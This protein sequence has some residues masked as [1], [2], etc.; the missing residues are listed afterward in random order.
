MDTFSHVQRLLQH[1]PISHT[2]GNPPFANYERKPS[3]AFWWR[4]RG[5]FQG[6]VETT[7]DMWFATKNEEKTH[8]AEGGVGVPGSNPHRSLFVL[9]FP[10]WKKNSQ[11]S[12]L[13]QGL[14]R[15]VQKKTV[16]NGVFQITPVITHWFSPIFLWGRFTTS[17]Y[18]DRLGQP[19]TW[20]LSTPNP[21]VFA[22]QNPLNLPYWEGDNPSH[23]LLNDPNVL[24]IN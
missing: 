19:P 10:C 15:W 21:K 3:L 12:K 1:T 11:N 9:F 23:L 22:L 17:I 5:V 24:G 7:F 8:P 13:F 4:F 14:A 16:L 6:C 2:P 20:C 18:N